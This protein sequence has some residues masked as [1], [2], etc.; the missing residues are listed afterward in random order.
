MRDCEEYL[1]EV[2]VGHGCV[3]GGGL[4]GCDK[5]GERACLVLRGCWLARSPVE[6]GCGCLPA[7]FE[8]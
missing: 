8:G 7:L 5:V 6:L 1:F 4:V 2:V 3:W